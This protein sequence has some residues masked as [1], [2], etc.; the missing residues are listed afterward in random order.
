MSWQVLN[1]AYAECI[2]CQHWSK[3]ETTL[4]SR[5]TPTIFS[6]PFSK[7]CVQTLSKS[8]RSDLFTSAKCAGS[9]NL[10]SPGSTVKIG[11]TAALLYSLMTAE[12]HSPVMH[13]WHKKLQEMEGEKFFSHA[14][15]VAWDQDMMHW[16]DFMQNFQV[17]KF[18]SSRINRL[19]SER[20]IVLCGF[21]LFSSLCSWW[22][23]LSTIHIRQIKM[24]AEF[25]TVPLLPGH[26]KRVHTPE[27]QQL[28][29]ASLQHRVALRISKRGGVAAMHAHTCHW[30]VQHC[31][32]YMTCH[33]GISKKKK[34]KNMYIEHYSLRAG[35]YE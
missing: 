19:L 9:R 20:K 30:L 18:F 1:A 29:G 28:S 8:H 23:A 31:T 16:N 10:V 4:I 12:L 22:H 25:S 2:S 32:D 26:S 27:V 14:T 13:A 15:E 17:I 21:T 34:K 3:H 5:H 7:L 6:A 33:T 35:A 11:L 24:E